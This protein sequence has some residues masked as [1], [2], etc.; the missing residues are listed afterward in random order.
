MCPASRL[1]QT[2]IRHDGQSDNSKHTDLRL[3]QRRD[4]PAIRAARKG[5]PEN[6]LKDQGWRVVFACSSGGNK[7][8][9]LLLQALKLRL[10]FSDGMIS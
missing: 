6:Q 9:T 7:L 8:I 4:F 10:E 5:A 2:T 1:C 3:L